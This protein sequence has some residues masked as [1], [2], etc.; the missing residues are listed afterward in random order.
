M[1]ELTT[2][3]RSFAEAYAACGNASEAARKAGYSLKTAASQGA[4]LLKHVHVAEQITQ[5]QAEAGERAAIE[6]DDVLDMLLAAV[7]DAKSAGQHGPSVRAVEL[8]GRHLA[9]FKDR[10]S[11]TEE[12]GASDDDLIEQLAA[13][14]G[15]KREMLRAVLGAEDSFDATQH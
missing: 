4:R 12:Q 3:Q 15:R 13:G 14:D 10:I 11:F 8:I 5:M 2:R 1:T 7:A 9:M 6:I